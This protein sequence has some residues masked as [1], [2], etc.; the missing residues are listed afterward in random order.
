MKTGA[1]FVPSISTSAP[2]F[3][4]SAPQFVPTGMPQQSNTMSVSG[5]SIFVPPPPTNQF[6]VPGPNGP[7]M[8]ACDPDGK[9]KTELCKNWIETAKCRYEQFCSFA[10]GQ[11]E[12]TKA[13]V[14]NYN[15]LF[16][17]KNC[18]TFYQTKSCPYGQRC[19]FRHEHRSFKQL[20]RHH[21]TPQLYGLETLYV[22]ATDKD[23]FI[24]D[25]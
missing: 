8:M 5:S 20:H 15:V 18:R 11:H 3:T 23:A 2:V 16:K 4:P 24:D 25:Y 17:S 21:Y 19:M 1:E 6:L 14:N 12:L 13:A 10:H 22:A 7:T 9:Y